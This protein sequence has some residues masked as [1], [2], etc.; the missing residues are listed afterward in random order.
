MGK[1]YNMNKAEKEL[2]GKPERNP[3]L[4]RPIHKKKDN[5]KMGFIKKM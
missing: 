1:R 4:G 3:P 5:I 2:I